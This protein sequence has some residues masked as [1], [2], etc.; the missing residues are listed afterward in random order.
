MIYRGPL[1]PRVSPAPLSASGQIAE[2]IAC[3][4]RLVVPLPCEQAMTCALVAALER[5]EIVGRLVAVGPV[6][7]G[8]VVRA[9]IEDEGECVP[10]GGGI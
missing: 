5:G 7:L 6:S 10:W 8:L 4:G 9:A 1:C 2:G 3:G